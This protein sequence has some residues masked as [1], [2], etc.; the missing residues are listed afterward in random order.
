MLSYRVTLCTN[1]RIAVHVPVS[2]KANEKTRNRR[3]RNCLRTEPSLKTDWVSKTRG[4]STGRWRWT[5]TRMQRQS[6][7][8]YE[9]GGLFC[10]RQ[11]SQSLSATRVLIMFK[12]NLII[13]RALFMS[14]LVC[15]K[16]SRWLYSY[17]NNNNKC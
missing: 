16:Y 3:V 2:R 8:V 9:G 13:N 4:R 11:V 17:N 5:S 15:N 7:E 10:K 6:T 1:A 14:S 12:V